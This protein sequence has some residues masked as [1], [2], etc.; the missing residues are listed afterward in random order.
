MIGYVVTV[1]LVVAKRIQHENDQWWCEEMF[2]YIAAVQPGLS[3]AH[4]VNKRGKVDKRSKVDA[5]ETASRLLHAIKI[6]RKFRLYEAAQYRKH[7]SYVEDWFI[8]TDIIE[9]MP[10]YEPPIS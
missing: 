5:T 7:L 6:G 4:E 9:G 8:H 3:A 10:N 2:D 1:R